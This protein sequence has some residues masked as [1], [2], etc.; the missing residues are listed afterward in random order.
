[1]TDIVATTPAIRTYGDANAALAAQVAAAG[2]TDQ[3]ATLAVAVPIFGLIGADFLA[4]FA[5]AQ[6][7]HFTSVNELAAVHAATALTAHQVAAEYEAA[8]A[9]SG[10]GFDSIERRR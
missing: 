10:A 7:N 6:A 8:E 1:M 9:V 3:A 2:A 5:T 4:A